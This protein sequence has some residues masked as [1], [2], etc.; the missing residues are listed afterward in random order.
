VKPLPKPNWKTIGLAALN[1]A[2]LLSCIVLWRA[3]QQW[4]H[5]PEHLPVR[6]LV[7]PDLKVLDV[8]AGHGLDVAA[9]RDNTIFHNRRLFYRAPAPSQAAPAPDYEFAG[10]MGLPQGKRVA[11]VKKKSDQ[12]GRS[13]HV[14]DDLDGWRVETIDASRVLLVREDQH[15]ELKAESNMPNAGLVTGSASPRTAHTGPLTLGSQGPSALAVP[16]SLALE[17]RTRQPPAH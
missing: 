15:L 10:S 7:M 17:A 4:V 1:G 16:R 9:I 13:L 5:A 14:G 2:L 11:F 3:G 8:A 12:S 6:S